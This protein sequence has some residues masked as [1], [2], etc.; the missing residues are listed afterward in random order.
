MGA[1][2]ARK[3]RIVAAQPE[4]AFRVLP[5]L[6]SAKLFD[7]HQRSSGRPNLAISLEASSL[8]LC[9]AFSVE[10]GH[11]LDELVEIH[12]SQLYR[13]QQARSG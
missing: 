8:S 4:V 1:D 3:C 11:K 6:E 10:R 13:N 2:P 12:H 9:N 7:R 5:F